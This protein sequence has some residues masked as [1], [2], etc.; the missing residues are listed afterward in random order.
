MD[1]H[2][3]L[4][5]GKVSAILIAMGTASFVLTIYHLIILCRNQH[6]HATNHN[7]SQQERSIT[8]PSPSAPSRSREQSASLSHLIPAHKYVKKKK[9]DDDVADGDGDE[10]DACAVCLGDF[11]EGEELRTLPECMHSFHV[12]CIDTWLH[13]HSSCPV[14]RLDATPSPA[15]IHRSPEL[16]SGESDAHHSID[17][18]HIALVQNGRVR[19]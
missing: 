6:P 2:Q 14:C 10:D 16:G 7:S 18:V 1:D 13:S 19:R 8:A 12:P 3:S 17:M 11:E 5:T 4:F 9:N 15:V